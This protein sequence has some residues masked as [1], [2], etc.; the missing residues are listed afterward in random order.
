MN[1]NLEIIINVVG[2]IGSALI[3]I[4]FALN[5]LKVLKS[6]SAKYQIM[7]LAGGAFVLWNSWYY[8]AFP[9][10]L[11]SVFWVIIAIVALARIKRSEV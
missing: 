3:I 4:A 2:Y 7:N 10:V 5:S 9:S 6:Y 11:V 1:N 8:H